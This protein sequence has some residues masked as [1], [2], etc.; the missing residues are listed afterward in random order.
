MIARN[1]STDRTAVTR[2]F[3]VAAHLGF[4]DAYRV[5]DALET[6]GEGESLIEAAEWADKGDAIESAASLTKGLGI[7]AE[8]AAAVAESLVRAFHGP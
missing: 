3:V 8:V 4:S 1:R 7:S 5:A 2:A 6:E